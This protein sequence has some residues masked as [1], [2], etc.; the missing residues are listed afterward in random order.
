MVQA[1]QPVMDVEF[2]YQSHVVNPQMANIV[3]PTEVLVVSNFHIDLEGGGGDIHI[4]YPYSMIEPIR[5]ILDAGV[6]SDR[7]D[8]DERWAI[9]LKEQLMNVKVEIQAIFAEKQLKVADLINFK[10]GDIIPLDLP[11]E[12]LVLAEEMPVM[13][14]QYG[15]H[16]GNSAVKV[17]ELVVI[18]GIE[19]S[20]VKGSI[21]RIDRKNSVPGQ[22]GKP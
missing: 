11:D 1:W 10:V 2:S 15:E 16:Q 5:P 14:G 19:N 21:T 18:S 4:I 22:P 9:L 6:R 7:G 17:R 13:R 8:I 3:S 20:A 12:V